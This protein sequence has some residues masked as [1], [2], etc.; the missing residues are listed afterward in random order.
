MNC[1]AER[2]FAGIAMSL[3]AILFL[4]LVQ[5][6]TAFEISSLSIRSGD[7]THSFTVELAR[8]P[9]ERSRGLM[10]RES[11]AADAGMLFDFGRVGRQAM[12]MKNT[13]LPLDMLF[14]RNDG[15][16]HHIQQR[17]QPQS[18]NIIPS[19][20]RVRAV[21]EL[22]GGTVERLGIKVGD[23]VEHPMFTAN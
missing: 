16:I 18:E 7:K 12:W 6:A 17:T 22:N 21:L 5:T 4:A 20:G 10:F 19:N 23:V 14:I 8:T 2:R 9:E 1:Y 13:Y 15:T 11:M 3:A